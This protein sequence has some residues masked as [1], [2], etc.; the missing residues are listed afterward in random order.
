[1]AGVL[2][3]LTPTMEP[4]GRTIR[5]RELVGGDPTQSRLVEVRLGCRPDRLDFHSGYCR[6]RLHGRFDQCG[7]RPRKGRVV[8]SQ[9][10]GAY[11]IRERNGLRLSAVEAGRLSG[12]ARRIKRDGTA[13]LTV[14]PSFYPWLR[15]R[16]DALNTMER[17]A[18]DLDQ[19]I[20][21][22]T[23]LRDL[24]FSGTVEM[25]LPDV[26]R[27]VSVITQVK[28][29]AVRARAA[30]GSVLPI[31]EVEAMNREVSDLFRRFVPAERM[32]ELLHEMQL[33]IARREQKALDECRR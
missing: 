22:L 10:G 13:D 28:A 32:P 27:L 21:K 23:A 25:D 4:T 15:E 18:L 29:N 1:M 11:A 3:K 7:K 24:V 2:R 5:V 33:N 31:A 6:A 19:D 26:V 12:L 17:E 16:A 9:H 14:I 20:V 30:A 8:C